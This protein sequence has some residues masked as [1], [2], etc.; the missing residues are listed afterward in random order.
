MKRCLG[1]IM[2][3]LLMVGAAN[4]MGQGFKLTQPNAIGGSFVATH[5]DGLGESSSAGPGLNLFLKYNISP[6]F[7]ITMGTGVHK[8]YDGSLSKDVVDITLFPIF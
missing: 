7:F 2:V 4:V 3:F 6:Q 1:I 5:L 8:I